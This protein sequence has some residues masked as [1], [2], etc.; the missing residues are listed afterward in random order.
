MEDVPLEAELIVG[1]YHQSLKTDCTGLYALSRA[2]ERALRDLVL[3]S[4]ALVPLYVFFDNR[5]SKRYSL[6]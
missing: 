2:W 5:I 3:P 6:L 1:K 4:P